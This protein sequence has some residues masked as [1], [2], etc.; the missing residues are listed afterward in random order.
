MGFF[1]FFRK[2]KGKVSFT[3]GI[4]K[5]T[6]YDPWVNT[7]VPVN[8]NYA[9]AAFV[10]MSRGGA[11]IGKSKDDYARYFNY[12]YGVYDPINYHK[13]VIAEGYLCEAAPNIALSHLKVNELKSILEGAGLPAGGR[14]D[15]LIARVIEGV[16]LASLNLDRYYIP[17]KMGEDHL[18][19]YGF[20]LDLPRYN[21][22]WEEFDEF[23]KA[24]PDNYKPNDLIWQMLN[25]QFNES[26]SSRSFGS[27]RNTLFDMGKFLEDEGKLTDA[28]FRY[29]LVLYYDT[30]GITWESGETLAPGVIEAIRRLRVQYSSEIVDRCYRYKLPYHS[31]EKAAFVRLLSDIFNEETVNIR[32][33]I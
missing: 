11:K 9:I 2:K 33:Y 20:V 27:A 21:I 22:S 16:N 32:D 4:C 7:G 14:K 12:R 26:N 13:R 23:K 30:N 29:V 19:K 15:A 31:I 3:G 17:S 6:E 28:L 8:N 25:S 5:P 18:K 24:Y 10:A 1:D